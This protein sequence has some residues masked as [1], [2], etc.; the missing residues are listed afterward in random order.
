MWHLKNE[1]T[2]NLSFGLDS[3]TFVDLKTTPT[4][5]GSGIKFVLTIKAQNLTN[6]RY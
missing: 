3:I 2:T 1:I 5:I 4:Q 6:T